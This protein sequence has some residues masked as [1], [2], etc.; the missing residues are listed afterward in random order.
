MPYLIRDV[1][2][3]RIYIHDK[4][5]NPPTVPETSPIF[6][7]ANLSPQLQKVAHMASKQLD[8]ANA[9]SYFDQVALDVGRQMV[10]GVMGTGGGTSL[11]ADDGT[12]VPS[13]W[14]PIA[15]HVDDVISEATLPALRERIRLATEALEVDVTRADATVVGQVIDELTMSLKELEAVRG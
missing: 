4:L 2:L 8:H 7:A 13:P 9:A 3:A 12:P 6:V 11:P 5:T 14:T 1:V 15:V 10:A